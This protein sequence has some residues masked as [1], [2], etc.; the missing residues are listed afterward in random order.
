MDTTRWRMPVRL[1]SSTN[2]TR[3][4]SSRGLFITQQRRACGESAPQRV[5]RKRSRGK[6]SLLIFTRPLTFQYTTRVV[7]VCRAVACGPWRFCSPPASLVAGPGRRGPRS[8]ASMRRVTALFRQV[9][10]ACVTA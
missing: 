3:E 2:G 7:F 9:Y 5:I 1:C 8:L 4:N 10:A 6:S